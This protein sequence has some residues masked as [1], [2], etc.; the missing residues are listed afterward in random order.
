MKK[1]IRTILFISLALFLSA[2]GPTP[3]DEVAVKFFNSLTSGDLRYVKRNIC[4]ADPLSYDAVCN[5]LDRVVNSPAYQESTAG[6]EADYVARGVTYEGD[7]AWVELRGVDVTGEEIT[8]IVR[9]VLVGEQWKVD[10][11]YSVLH[12]EKKQMQQ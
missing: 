12:P 5:Y 1:N 9:M 4:F 8:T 11:D 3:P 2:C 10:G 7:V 6:Y